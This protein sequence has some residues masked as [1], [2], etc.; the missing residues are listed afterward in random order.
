M[1]FVHCPSPMKARKIVL[2]FEWS[3]QQP[4]SCT[5]L[6][7]RRTR[8]VLGQSIAPASAKPSAVVGFQVFTCQDDNQASQAQRA[9]ERP[10]S[11]VLDFLWRASGDNRSAIRFVLHEF[12]TL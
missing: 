10:V 8:C 2:P 1:N 3:A 4:R 6:I 11:E 5:W 9:R 12:S 7:V